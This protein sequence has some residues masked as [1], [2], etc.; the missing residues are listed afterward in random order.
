MSS[1]PN[2]FL[3]GYS[4]LGVIRQLCVQFDDGRPQV[5]RAIHPSQRHL[6]DEQLISMPCAMTSHVA[7]VTN[8][9][10][11][12]PPDMPGSV[13]D[14]GTVGAVLYSICAQDLDGGQFHIGDAYSAEAAQ[15]VVKRLSFVTGVYS[16][17]WEISTAHLSEAAWRYLEQGLGLQEREN[18]LFMRFRLPES[19]AIGVKL[20]STPWTDHHLTACEGITVA[21]LS[22]EHL[23]SGMPAD[24]AAILALAGA[25]DV[26]ILVFDADAPV[27]PGLAPHGQLTTT[28]A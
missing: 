16:R 17:C 8:G 18:S 22:A 24:L 7:L 21:Q 11:S 2:P 14:E 13:T 25:A 20:I 9:S 27:L 15:E 3:R 10:S 23:A 12:D 26:R 6:T 1:H 5:S 19:P 4:T 28:D